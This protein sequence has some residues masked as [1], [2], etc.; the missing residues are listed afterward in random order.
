MLLCFFFIRYN[1]SIEASWPPKIIPSSNPCLSALT[2]PHP[3]AFKPTKKAFHLLQSYHTFAQPIIPPRTRLHVLVSTL[4][5]TYSHIFFSFKWQFFF[6]RLA[7]QP[8]PF[9]L[10]SLAADSHLFFSKNGLKKKISA[11]NVAKLMETNNNY[12][13]PRP[14][15]IHM[16]QFKAPCTPFDHQLAGKD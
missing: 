1:C 16:P 15:Y 14:T 12:H 3:Y 9:G 8:F 4:F 10:C 2:P 13:A 11:L 5:W 6:L 7:T